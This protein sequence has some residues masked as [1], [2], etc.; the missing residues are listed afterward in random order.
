[1]LEVTFLEERKS[2]YDMDFYE[3]KFFRDDDFEAVCDFLVANQS[4]K[5]YDYNNY[6]SLACIGCGTELE[7]GNIINIIGKEYCCKKCDESGAW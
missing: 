5:L 3:T 2:K 6:C 4:Y 1:M 7:V